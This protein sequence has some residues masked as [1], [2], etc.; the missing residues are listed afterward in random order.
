MEAARQKTAT[1]APAPRPAPAVQPIAAV[2]AARDVRQ[3]VPGVQ[4]QSA[5]RVSS[6]RDPAE[7]EAEATA[8]QILRM[9]EPEVAFAGS[10]LPSQGV[11]RH[12]PEPPSIARFAD[13]V[14]LMRERGAPPIA[15]SGA[16][17]PPVTSDVAAEIAAEKGGGS[18]LPRGVRG[19]MEARFRADFSPVRVHTG[20]PAA[21]LNR[22][23]QAQAF[24][25][26]NHVFF[27]RDRFR[28]EAPE[29]RELLAHELT[30]TIQQ[31]AAVQRS[32]EVAV[33]ER[34]AG[35]VQRLGLG[36]VL[37]Y[38]A[39]KAYVIPGFR[40]LT[41]ALGVNPITMSAVP[42]SAA[43]ILRAVVELLPGGGLIT[44]ALDRYGIFD[45]AGAWVERELSSL[46]LTAAS[47][48]QAI[49][50]FVDTLGAA[51]L[52][53]PG[54]AWA[55]ARAILAE[56]ADRVRCSVKSLGSG[57]L[58]FLREATI[59]PLAA[60]AAS[61]PGWDLLCAVLGR[62]PITGASVPR[63]AEALIGGFMRLIGQGEIW[64]NIKKAN[65]GARALA[66]FEG[67]LSGLLGFVQQIPGLFTQA[68]RSLE[69]TDVVLPPLAFFKVAKV[70]GG[71][72]GKFVS[73]A[74]GTVW[75]L[76]EILF[77]VVAPELLVHLRKAGAALRKILQDPIGF[78][79]NLVKAGTLGLSQFAGNIVT[80]LKKALLDWL[81]GSLSG[82][83]IYLPQALTPAE[84]GKCVLSVLG[85]T[86]A[87]IRGKI[88]KA[89]GP[90]GETIMKS[91]E[92]GFDIV[93]ALVQGGPAAAW[94]LIQDKLSDLRDTVLGMILD[95]VKNSI[96]TA[97]VKKIVGMLVPGGAFLTA[98][99]AIYDTI[100]VFV[101]RLKQIAAVVLAFVDSLAAIANGAVGAAAN[102]VEQAMAGALSIVLAFLARFAGLGKVGAFL[103]AKLGALRAKVDKALDK[104]VEWIVAQAKRAGRFIQ[105]KAAAVV[106]W[107]RARAQFRTGGKGHSLFF[108]GQGAGAQL[109]VRSE[110]K[111]LRD[112]LD[113]DVRPKVPTDHPNAG[114]IPLIE[115]E[116]VK[117]D[118]IK[119][120][121]PDESDKRA[122]KS[123]GQEGGR[124]IQAALDEI[125]KLLG[126]L[127]IVV[128]PS[129]VTHEKTT[130]K[131]G[132]VVGKAMVAEPLTVNPGGLAGSAPFAETPTWMAVKRRVGKYI[133]GHL[134]NHH[135]HGAGKDENLVPISGSLN[136]W[137]SSNVEEKVKAAVLG[138]G[139]IVRYSVQFHFGTHAGTRKIPQ[140]L[141][142]PTAVDLT[143]E[144]IENVNGAWKA[145]QTIAAISGKKH[146][147]PP[148]SDPIDVKPVLERLDLNN[149][150][151]K[152]KKDDPP[153]EVALQTL[154]HIG[155]VRA[156]SLQKKNRPFATWE[157]VV[158]FLGG[159]KGV[160]Q[161]RAAEIVKTWQ[162]QT[163]PRVDLKGGTEWVIPK[164][165][166][167]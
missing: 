12:P 6:P 26:G 155:E 107:W 47:I 75:N 125:A 140:E 127:G 118:E 82:A 133:R 50:R 167:T 54:S 65:A 137:M 104:A 38:F 95:F 110:Q 41:V 81:M 149:P 147:L 58:R 150:E 102:R 44:Q 45:K 84:I 61:T 109:T 35:E 145:K 166:G 144:E 63:T 112:Y 162:S 42:R 17:Q 165:E 62:N 76:L 1:H 157:D 98:I 92:T 21:R 100:M 4:L 43:N 160:G 97:A 143:A 37:E 29:G 18:P 15:R 52:L 134:L 30:H 94:E 57:I 72:L 129:K 64:E 99:L 87:Q 164:S 136:T 106:E 36:D 33:G 142:L 146:E 73:W 101:E 85:V 51:D 70:F 158:T 77:S 138:H 14:H 48:K 159:L 59:L 132:S 27:A 154:P 55:R 80:H 135:L 91:L 113:K 153:A 39:E 69:I 16:G 161:K 53:S 117:I 141:D 56:P 28:P 24:T 9:A 119:L 86:W 116:I 163:R 89:L 23:L 66:W 5:L 139:K 122:G 83:G 128:P 114:K 79:R 115:A 108:V 131:D 3:S 74:G 71:F 11:S 34:S 148:D 88:V 90:S 130:L 111:T 124:K 103:V 7:R 156:D 96:V 123:F 13:A 120:K 46:G 20:E 93:V 8:R 2:I 22:K 25:H 19:F 78:V 151:G 105:E 60:L 32:P 121:T 49:T 67:A 126:A 40:L 152:N 68:L 10:S 31:G